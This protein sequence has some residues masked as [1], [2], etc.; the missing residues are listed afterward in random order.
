VVDETPEP[1]VAGQALEA[2]LERETD[3]LLATSGA[4]SVSMSAVIV[5]TTAT[6]RCCWL[7]K[8]P[9]R[10]GR[11]PLAR[12]ESVRSCGSCGRGRDGVRLILHLLERPGERKLARPSSRRLCRRIAERQKLLATGPA[13]G[14][15]REEWKVA[16]QLAENPVEVTLYGSRPRRLATVSAPPPTRRAAR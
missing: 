1:K 9:R 4:G 2:D 8:L 6:A 14:E 12:R 15:G 16:R 11:G 13:L 10:R 3:S 7:T 5:P